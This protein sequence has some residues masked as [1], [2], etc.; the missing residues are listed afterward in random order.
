VGDATRTSASRP[1]P[2]AYP[3]GW[4]CHHHHHPTPL[5]DHARIVL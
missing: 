5:R 2:E 3:P 4:L 1:R